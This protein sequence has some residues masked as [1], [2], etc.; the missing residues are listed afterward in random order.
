MN[1]KLFRSV[2]KVAKG[3]ATITGIRWIAKKLQDWLIPDFDQPGI[4]IERSG[5]DNHIPV[6][7]GEVGKAHCIKVLKHGTESDKRFYHCI[8][9]FSEGP[10]EAIDELFFDGISEHDDRF[11]KGNGKWFHKEIFLGTPNQPHCSTLTQVIPNWDADCNLPGLAYVYVRFEA[12]ADYKVWG[13]K[14]PEITARIRGRKVLDIRTGQTVYSNNPALCLYDYLSNS[15]Y[16]NSIDQNRLLQQ[17]ITAAANFYD[18]GTTYNI[19]REECYYDRETQS[20]I[21]NPATVESRTQKLLTFNCIIDT[22][23]TVMSNV[24]EILQGMRAWLPLTADKLRLIV[25]TAGEPVFDITQD[26]QIGSIRT[27]SENRSERYNRVIVRYNNK[28]KDYERDE[29]V[30]PPKDSTLHQTWLD[31]DNGILNETSV[32]LRSITSTGEALQMAELIAKRSRHNR[33]YETTILPIGLKLE[34][35]DL[36][37]VYNDLRGIEAKP[38]RVMSLQHDADLNVTLRLT[39]HQNAVYPWSGTD[40]SEIIRN[41]N[42]GDPNKVIAPN[43]LSLTTD[44]D[45]FFAGT[46]TW[47]MPSAL[48]VYEFEVRIIRVDDDSIVSSEKVRSRSYRIPLLN[49]G[50]YS[51]NVRAFNSLGF[52]SGWSSLVFEL[53]IPLAPSG[54]DLF[55][56]NFEIEA[57]PILL[58]AGLGT[59]FEFDCI[60]GDG[61]GHAPVVK[62]RGSNATFVGLKHNTLHTVFARTINALGN[63]EWVSASI[64]TTND[65]NN[66]IDLI[67]GPLW[68]SVFEP[69]VNDL[70]EQIAEAREGIVTIDNAVKL[71]INQ[72]RLSTEAAD[73]ELFNTTALVRQLRQNQSDITNAIFEVDPQT[74]QIRNLAY[75]YTDA[76]FTQAGLLI[77]GVKGEI[78]ITSQRVTSTEMRLTNAESSLALLPGQIALKAS[79]TEVNAAIASAIDAVLPAY[80]FGFFNSAEG[81]VAI[82]GTITPATSKVL[83][84]KGDVANTALDYLADDNPLISLSIERTAGD[85]WVGAVIVSFA[86]AADQTYTGVIEDVATGTVVVRNLNLGGEASYTGKVTGIR[87]ILGA[88]AAD[89][90]TLNSVTIGKPSAALTELEGVTVQINQ[91][92]LDLNAVDAKFSGYVTTTFYNENSVTVNNVELVLNGVEGYANL[93]A[94]K[95]ELDAEGTLE[96]ANSAAIWIDAAEANITQAVETYNARPGG[97][98]EQLDAIDDSFTLVQSQIDASAGLVQDQVV[99]LSRLGNDTRDLGLNQ[100]LVEYQLYLR[101]K[102]ELQLGVGVATAT[103][104]IQ[105]LANNAQAIAQSVLDLQANFG[106]AVGQFNAQVF[107]INQAISSETGAVATKIS[108][109]RASLMQPGTGE[110]WAVSESVREAKTAADGAQSA[111]SGLR[112]A[113]GAEG[114]NESEV[115]SSAEL[116]LSTIKNQAQEAVSRAALTVSNVVDGKAVVS[117]LTIG[118]ID[119]GIEMR[120]NVFG[121]SNAAGEPVL[122]WTNAG[123]LLNIRCRLVLSDN[124]TVDNIDDIRARD[125][126]FTEFRYRS[127]ATPP[128]TPTDVNPSGWSKTPPNTTSPIWVVQAEKVADGTALI[129]SWS[130]P[131]RFNGLP[132]ADGVNARAVVLTASKQAITYNPNGKE[133]NPATVTFEATA[134]NTVGTVFYRFY[135]NDEAQGTQATTSNAFSY[136]LPADKFTQ[137]ISVEVEVREGSASGAIVARD[138]VSLFAVKDGSDAITV[139]LSNESHAVVAAADGTVTAAARAGS[140]TTIKVFEGSTPLIFHAE[141]NTA[142][143]ITQRGRYRVSKQNVGVGSASPTGVDTDTFVQGDIT[144][145]AQANGQG[146]IIYT[147]RVRKLDGSTAEIIKE[148]TFTKSKQGVAGQNGSPGQNTATLLAYK[149]SATQ[150]QDNP[151]N[152][153][154]NFTTA[155]WTPGNG[156]SK[157]VPDSNGHPCYVVSAS[158]VSTT[159]S[160]VIAANEWSGAVVLAQ[161]G[162]DGAPGL[163][164]ATVMLYRRT[165]GDA[166][167]APTANVTYRFS[168][169]LISGGNNGWSGNIPTDGGS[170]LWV[171]QATAS[172]TSA[173]DVLA[174]SEW[175][176]PRKLAIDGN[177]AKVLEVSAS[178]QVISYRKDN[179]RDISSITFNV[180]AQGLAGGIYE[181]ELQAWRANG[182]YSPNRVTSD[183]ALSNDRWTVNGATATLD[184]G[185]TYNVFNPNN[186][187]IYYRIRVRYL[188]GNASQAEDVITIAKLYDGKDTLSVLLSNESHTLPADSNGTVVSF[189][190]SGTELRVYAGSQLL[191][192]NAESN[193]YP[194]SSAAGTYNV[195]LAVTNATAGALSGAGEAVAILQNLQGLSADTGNITFTIRVRLPDGSTQLITKV[196]SLAKA[197]AGEK[198]DKGDTGIGPAGPVGAGF[199]GSTYAAISWT[200]STANQRFIE[201]T[202]RAPVAFDVFTQT[203]PDGTDSQARQY[204][205]S[206]WVA[207]ALQVNGSIVAKGTIAGDRFMAGTE[208]T[209]PV[210]KG[211]E[212]IVADSAVEYMSVIRALPFGQANDLVEWFGPR[213][214]GVTWNNTTMLPIYSGMTKLNAKTYKTKSGDVF[215]GGTFQA[216]A[217][218]ISRQSTTSAGSLAVS[219][220]PFTIPGGT[221]ALSVTSSLTIGGSQLGAG[222]CPAS[223]PSFSLAINIER[224]VGGTWQSIGG[225]NAIVA[226]SCSQEGPE[227]IIALTGGVTVNT[228]LS[229][230][231]GQSVSL[232]ATATAPAFPTQIGGLNLQGDRSLSLVVSGA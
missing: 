35:G 30:Y 222:W 71:R 166:P 140:G 172:A 176:T 194:L 153:T 17:L 91:L 146:K 34:P 158:A 148:Q 8:A 201:L 90:F 135:V 187:F 57:R 200:T 75:A 175:S 118:G 96:K 212:V 86:D 188:I 113:I 60:E 15:L 105:A 185:S 102:G 159:N 141:G 137:A 232:R 198:G 26:M 144:S 38:Y 45:Q 177:N 72:L 59:Q 1:K 196:Q 160:D 106:T 49:I 65:A 88:T 189:A 114:E 145:F 205:G 150:P 25:E 21:C 104:S 219:S 11:K 3:L 162:V 178:S 37:A 190:G 101:N 168:D 73:R 14:D 99:A 16:G 2:G 76:Q 103:Q 92:G 174:P 122:Y 127:T 228:N 36:V 22:S 67:S 225:N 149:R 42:L 206:S 129:G 95:Q 171:I 100:L 163:N 143:T 165:N 156:W 147:I 108:D 227:M 220:D 43:S 18:S 53:T 74:G 89:A 184:V 164:V 28:D 52:S 123:G 68:E 56:Y 109:L 213:I 211:G 152:V 110:I 179:S 181:Y 47:S 4:E 199:Y 214:N 124:T 94:F 46:L 223:L 215:F 81:W 173:T 154:Y 85:G 161:D 186:E 169:G 82:S 41:T 39:E 151:G 217:L 202:G 55:S 20:Y 69:T 70:Q 195:Q 229:V 87:L 112:T 78:E 19:T 134:F 203:R 139:I 66:V 170:T 204:N 5:T 50:E 98:N 142:P 79:Y 24:R 48:Q 119:N 125:G 111:V 210:I 191:T 27:V 120:G 64:N 126:K 44:D 12:D 131:V 93:I 167:V 207:V 130:A 132:G 230:S 10:I 77:D 138:E 107:E 197:R 224:L 180:S 13:S 157:T 6:I 9:V 58:G 51:A 115:Q 29:V 182:T 32:L 33:T 193:T 218:S 7:Y 209:A 183:G 221:T 54:I 208:I 40:Y 133:P 62:G 231:A 117:G 128:P 136:A 121:L 226:A 155:A 83:L 216:G 31:E 116:I 97:L 80:S 84:T 61:A 23:N 192:F 63:S